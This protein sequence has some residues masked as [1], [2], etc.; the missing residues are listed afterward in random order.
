MT[1]SKIYLNGNYTTI[2]IFNILRDVYTK[3]M[4]D[5]IEKDKILEVKQLNKRSK[6]LKEKEQISIQQNIPTIIKF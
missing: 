4:N 3:D 2:Q 6:V 1:G 5:K